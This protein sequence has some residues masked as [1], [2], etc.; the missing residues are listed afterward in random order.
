MFTPPRIKEFQDNEF[1]DVYLEQCIYPTRPDNLKNVEQFQNISSILDV[2]CG[3]GYFAYNLAE[4]YPNVTVRGIDFHPTSIYE[5]KDR[6]HLSN[7]RFDEMDIN[8]LNPSYSTFDATIINYSLHHFEDIDTAIKNIA[9]VIN[10]GGTIIISD[11]DR[12]YG[13]ND[14]EIKE[15]YQ[16]RKEW[17]LTYKKMFVEDLIIFNSGYISRDKALFYDS[18]IAAFTLDE[19]CESLETNGM[20]V[21]EMDLIENGICLTTHHIIARKE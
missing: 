5:A 20:S 10:Q 17:G 21:Q 7:L 3:S 11:F 16:T 13:L 6:G 19:V 1:L 15:W 8:N 18:V 12:E 14:E 2:A 9:S 4:Q